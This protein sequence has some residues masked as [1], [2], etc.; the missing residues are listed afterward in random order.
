MTFAT[1]NRYREVIERIAKR[2]KTDELKVASKV[3]EFAAAAHRR[4][5]FQ[6]GVAHISV[7]T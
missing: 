2:T 3:I 5:S 1:R 6:I 7:T 4:D